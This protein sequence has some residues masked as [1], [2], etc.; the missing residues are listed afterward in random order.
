MYTVQKFAK[1]FGVCSGTVR[2]WIKQK[3]ITPKINFGIQTLEEVD[4]EFIKK[5][6]EAK[7]NE[8]IKKKD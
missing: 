2:Y 7:K 6:R 1:I 8:T 4:V 3:K 5:L